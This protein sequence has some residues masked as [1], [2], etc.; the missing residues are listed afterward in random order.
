LNLFESEI[1]KSIEYWE[2]KG[3]LM[4]EKIRE[5]V[6]FGSRISTGRSKFDFW[7]L[8]D[9][10][11]YA[12]ECKMQRNKKSFNLSDISIIDDKQIRTLMN[13]ERRG[14]HG[15]LGLRTEVDEVFSSEC[16]FMRIGPILKYLREKMAKT[17]PI[18]ALRKL[19]FVHQIEPVNYSTFPGVVSS[20][21][22][23]DVRD[24]SLLLNKYT[25]NDL[26]LMK[27]GRLKEPP[28]DVILETNEDEDGF[29]IEA[30]VEE[31]AGYF[32]K[33]L[34]QKVEETL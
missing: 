4:G 18:D 21:V 20:Y 7:L 32:D 15:V 24:I 9:G 13:V 16:F 23:W 25:N 31:I 8:I 22:I 3:V 19:S 12:L 33:I 14:G 11:F 2:D 29:D 34:I 1:E 17:I 26:T 27:Q 30:A 28:Y 5:K 10:F 6:P